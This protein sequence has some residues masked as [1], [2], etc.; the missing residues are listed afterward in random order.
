MFRTTPLQDLDKLI[1]DRREDV[2]VLFDSGRYD[3]AF[4][5]CGYVMEIGLKKKIC[6]A[7]GW[8]SY[9]PGNHNDLKSFKTHE[10]EVL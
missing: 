2:K 8:Q 3:G 7:L 6:E 1:K 9:P 5:F 10:L 4:Y